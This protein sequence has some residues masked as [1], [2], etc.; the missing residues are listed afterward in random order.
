MRSG[1]VVFARTDMIHNEGG[2][3]TGEEEMAF[4]RRERMI[5]CRGS[6]LRGGGAGAG[7]VEGSR[8]ADVLETSIRSFEDDLLVE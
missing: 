6:T 2:S 3:K 4:V 8:E 5:I 1:F 7:F